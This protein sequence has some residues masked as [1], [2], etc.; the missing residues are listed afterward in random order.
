MYKFSLSRCHHCH[1]ALT[2]FEEAAKLLE[3]H[4]I[5]IGKLD[6]EGNKETKNK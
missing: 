1:N 2:V 3:P 4:G 6:I 5:S